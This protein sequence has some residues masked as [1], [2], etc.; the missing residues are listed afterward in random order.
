MSMLYHS[1]LSV[2][3][4]IKQEV[5]SA[6]VTSCPYEKQMPKCHVN[7]FVELAQFPRPMVAGCPALSTLA[8]QLQPLLLLNKGPSE[9]CYATEF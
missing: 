1:T 3:P 5:F 7:R 6:L 9:P 8:F 2:G 4:L